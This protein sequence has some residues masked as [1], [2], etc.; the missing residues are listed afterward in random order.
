LKETKMVD[1]IKDRMKE[2][3]SYAAAAVGGVGIGV[4]IDQ[5]IVI[6]VAVGA[7]AIAFVLREKGIL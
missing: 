5:P 2:P 3:S 7:A 1:W 6:M 4:L